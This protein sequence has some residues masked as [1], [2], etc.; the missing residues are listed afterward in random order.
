MAVFATAAPSMLSMRTAGCEAHPE[1]VPAALR[2]VA[3]RP[4][5]VSRP[6]PKLPCLLAMAAV[7]AARSKN[8]AATR[9]FVLAPSM[10]ARMCGII[11]WLR[12]PAVLAA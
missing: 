2:T 6:Y 8:P 9:L 10:M 12:A 1:L 7:S 5:S 3:E 11:A 4:A